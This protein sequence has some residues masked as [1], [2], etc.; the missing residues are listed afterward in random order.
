MNLLVLLF[1][2]NFKNLYKSAQIGNADKSSRTTY[3]SNF[4][5]SGSNTNNLNN[6]HYKTPKTGYFIKKINHLRKDQPNKSDVK[7]LIAGL[8]VLL[9]YYI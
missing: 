2:P 1:Y 4:F 3:R 7:H 6:N 5:F 8:K 9:E